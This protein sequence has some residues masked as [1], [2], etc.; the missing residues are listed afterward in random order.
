MLRQY[1]SKDADRKWRASFTRENVEGARLLAHKMRHQTVE[2]IVRAEKAA[3]LEREAKDDMEARRVARW[4]AKDGADKIQIAMDG[5]WAATYKA[6][7]GTKSITIYRNG[8][9]IE[10]R[11][12]EIGNLVEEVEVPLQ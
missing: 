1:W 8:S 6:K 7:A 9:K 10:Q 11:F 2:Q 5:D 3:H 12:D 4:A